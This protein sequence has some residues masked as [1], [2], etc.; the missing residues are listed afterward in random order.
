MTETADR[1]DGLSIREVETRTG[2][3]PDT[4]R[5]YERYGLLVHVARDSRGRRVYRVDDVHLLE[6]LHCLRRTGMSMRQ[7]AEFAALVRQGRGTEP[8]R[9]GLLEEHRAH[10]QA[11]RAQL[12]RDLALIDEK[13]AKYREES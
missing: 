8:N 11:R 6:V 1:P 5:Y 4:L 9:L 12:D 7:A 10:A 3:S 13:I 2:L